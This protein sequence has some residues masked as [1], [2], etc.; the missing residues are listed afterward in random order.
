MH[1]SG[2]TLDSGISACRTVD[3]PDNFITLPGAAMLR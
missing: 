1:T 2:L 3:A